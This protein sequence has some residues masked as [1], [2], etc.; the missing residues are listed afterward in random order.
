MNGIIKIYVDPEQWS[1]RP[2]RATGIYT[3]T[4]EPNRRYRSESMCRWWWQSPGG[5]WPSPD[6]ATSCLMNVLQ[7]IIG[8]LYEN[9]PLRR[10][11]CTCHVRMLEAFYIVATR[12]GT[13]QPPTE[14]HD[15]EVVVYIRLRTAGTLNEVWVSRLT[16]NTGVF[17]LKH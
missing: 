2:A 8:D 14:D 1:C 17:T 15:D 4:D 12:T 13:L 6:T 11:I 16:Y 3:V 7:L 5:Q 9:N 10:S